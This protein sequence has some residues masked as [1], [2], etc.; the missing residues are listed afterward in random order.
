M[1]PTPSAVVLELWVYVT[2]QDLNALVVI[3]ILLF[4]FL[5]H[6]INMFY[7]A[8]RLIKHK[9]KKADE[10]QA[11]S[12]T[13]DLTGATP[14]EDEDKVDLGHDYDGI[15]ELDNPMLFFFKQKTAYEIST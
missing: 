14:I 1:A 3:T 2:S 5:L 4:A 10:E 9:D 6:M 11:A 13:R 7:K 8:L 12:F 15:R